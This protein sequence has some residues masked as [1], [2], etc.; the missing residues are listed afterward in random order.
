MKPWTRNDTKEW[1]HQLENR[2][3][4]IDYYLKQTINWCENNDVYDDR[5]V[6][7][8]SFLTVIWVSHLRDEPISYIE[9]LEILGLSSLIQGEDKLYDLGPHLKNLDHED[10]LKMV[11]KDIGK[12]Q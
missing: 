5:I 3:E 11:L 2:L 12:D 9:L 6:L 7:M 10:M 8:L 4:D 1:I